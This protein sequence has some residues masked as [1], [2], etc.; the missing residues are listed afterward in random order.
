MHARAPGGARG[1]GDDEL[2]V[3]T[4]GIAKTALLPFNCLANVGSPRPCGERGAARSHVLPAGAERHV[5]DI[6]ALRRSNNLVTL[7]T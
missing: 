6:E 1:D 5:L 7:D 2:S 4:V 3:A